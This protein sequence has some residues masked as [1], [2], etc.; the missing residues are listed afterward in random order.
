[1]ESAL[2]CPLAASRSSGIPACAFE[3]CSGWLKT[4]ALLRKVR[5]RGVNKVH[6]ALPSP[7]LSTIW[8]ACETWLPQFQ[9]REWRSMRVFTSIELAPEATKN[10]GNQTFNI[11]NNEP[12]REKHA[13]YQFFRSLLVLLCYKLYTCERK[14]YV[15]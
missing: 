11:I 3:E 1:M 15:S 8:C 9:R 14:R 4:I 13:A 7:A 2:R 12:Q 5:H 6:W 10:T